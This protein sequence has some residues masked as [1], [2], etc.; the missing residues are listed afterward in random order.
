M[1]ATRATKQAKA[2]LALGLTMDE[3]CHGAASIGSK[4]S[5]A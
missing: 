4:P 5:A 3:L 1:L 2:S